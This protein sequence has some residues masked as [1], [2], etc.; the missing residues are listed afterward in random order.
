MT[1]VKKSSD[2]M[3]DLT[4]IFGSGFSDEIALGVNGLET[5]QEALKFATDETSRAGSM[6]KEYASRSR[7][8]ANALILLKNAGARL[9]ITIGNV[10]LPPIVK[11]AEMAVA[12]ISPV[13]TLA[14]EFPVL[15]RVVMTA[16][17]SLVALKVAAMGGMYAA[18]IL[19]DGWVYARNVVNFF[20]LSS[21]KATAAMVWQRGAA[22][23][24]GVGSRVMAAGMKIAAAGQWLLNNAMAANPAGMAIRGAA[25]LVGL[26]YHLYNTCEP[27]RAVFDS[28]F[29]FIGEKIGWAFGKL[30]TIYDWFTDA[31]EAADTATEKIAKARAAGPAMP[32]A[33]TIL[34]PMPAAGP[35]LTPVMPEEWDASTS[36]PGSLSSMLGQMPDL[37]E[38]MGED[39][40][41]LPADM[42]GPAGAGGG[43]TFN[44][45]FPINGVADAEFG[46]RVI[47]ALE[48][49]RRDFETL[50][51]EIVGEQRRLT[52]GQ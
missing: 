40:G 33:Q 2:P 37:G 11:A 21:L 35:A 31:D 9:G 42:S 43:M 48:S 39:M 38:G 30:K 23:A 44:L 7:T 41:D 6:N 13:S 15:T 52:Y 19:S 49:R 27:V 45:S 22:I 8:T 5:Y 1:A 36:D 25:A 32:T 12:L 17:I 26:M 29:G 51:A 14:G 46:K 16:G 47:S 20:R 10:L 28:V 34:P 24:L 18:T 50:I 3:R 4:A